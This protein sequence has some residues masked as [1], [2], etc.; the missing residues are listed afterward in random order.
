MFFTKIGELQY[1]EKIAR[2]IIKTLAG[3]RTFITGNLNYI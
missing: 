2:R 1:S 3:E